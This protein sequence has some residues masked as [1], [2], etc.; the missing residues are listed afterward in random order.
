MMRWV[1]INDIRMVLTIAGKRLRFWSGREF[2]DLFRLTEEIADALNIPASLEFAAHET[3]HT[4]ICGICQPLIVVYFKQIMTDMEVR[5][6]IRA[7]VKELGSQIALARLAGVSPQY[8]T[9]V[10]KKR[11]RAGSKLLKACGYEIV[12]DIRAIA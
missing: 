1:F 7:K 5:A 6:L 3:K 11:R 10:L 9:D 4:L 12:R 8:L 2:C